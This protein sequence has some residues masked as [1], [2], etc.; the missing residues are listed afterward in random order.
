[1]RKRIEPTISYFEEIN[2]Y[3]GVYKSTDTLFLRTR[4]ILHKESM[5]SVKY[6]Y[7]WGKCSVIMSLLGLQKNGNLHY[8]V[9]FLMNV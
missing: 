2:L 5:Y 1:M 4:F 3:R 8:P 7:Q 6:D 9:Y